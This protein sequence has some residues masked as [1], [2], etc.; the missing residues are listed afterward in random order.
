V[1]RTL[2]TDRATGAAHEALRDLEPD[3]PAATDSELADRVRSQIFRPADVPKGAVSVNAEVG[4]VYL[5]GE[6]DSREQIER[7]V[8]A[9]KQVEGV[10]AVENLL[11]TPGQPAPAKQE[12]EPE[13]HRRVAD[14][15]IP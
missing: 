10:R 14:S 2:A 13:T 3:R 8:D 6:V 5:R 15:H 7:L 12:T 9:A 1:A 11:H 4:I